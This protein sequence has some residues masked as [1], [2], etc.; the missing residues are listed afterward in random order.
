MHL[1]NIKRVAHENRPWR[2][3]YTPTMGL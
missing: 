3:L 2:D 1:I